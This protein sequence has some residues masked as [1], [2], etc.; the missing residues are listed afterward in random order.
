M[1]TQTKPTVKTSKTINGLNLLSVGS[2]SKTIK[3]EKLGYK[4]GV[5]YLAPAWTSKVE[6]KNGKLINVCTH[7]S[8]ECMNFCLAFA[9]R[10][11]IFKTI[12]IARQRKTALLFSDRQTFLSQL[13]S[14]VSKVVN[15]CN[16]NG[17]IPAF[18][19][20]GTSDIGFQDMARDILNSNPDVMF[21]DY[22]KVN[23][24]YERFLSGKLPVNY[25]LTFSRSED[26]HDDCLE[27][28]ENG[29]NG[30]YQKPVGVAVVF[31]IKPGHDLPETYHGFPVIDGDKSD[32]RF[33]D[34]ETGYPA[35]IVGLRAKGKAKGKAQP[36]EYGFVV[37]GFDRPT[38]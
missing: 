9:G 16:R 6:T 10:A 32:L 13:S 25:H 20:N 5:L 31:D 28:L 17:Y 34:T 19:F 23:S 11:G 1:E 12:Q 14:D 38:V 8:Y 33:L 29:Q 2:D 7:A 27:Y 26:N 18:R 4:T 3:G 36:N 35:Y 37:K 15:W 21:Y 30:L 22:T 24:R